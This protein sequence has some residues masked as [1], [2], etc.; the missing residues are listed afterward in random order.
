MIYKAT[1][2]KYMSTYTATKLQLHSG[3]D[4]GYAAQGSVQNNA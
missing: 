3:T 1:H 2:L 4:T